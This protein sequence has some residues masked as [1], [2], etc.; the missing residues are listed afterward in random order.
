MVPVQPHGQVQTHATISS[1]P[2]FLH[3]PQ[4]LAKNKR[5]L[6]ASKVFKI[7]QTT[8]RYDTIRYEKLYFVRPKQK[9][10]VDLPHGTEKKKKS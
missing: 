4:L 10:S 7:L 8:L 1:V 6:L 5:L 2:P 9:L 3:G